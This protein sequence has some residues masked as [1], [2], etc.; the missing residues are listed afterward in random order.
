M[1]DKELAEM[2]EYKKIHTFW[3][4]LRSM[5]DKFSR[6][7]SIASCSRS[8]LN[9]SLDRRDMRKIREA[10][11]EIEAYVQKLRDNLDLL[12]DY[13]E[14]ACPSKEPKSVE[15]VE[16]GGE[17]TYKFVEGWISTVEKTEVIYIDIKL[18]DGKIDRVPVQIE[19]ST[20]ETKLE[21]VFDFIFRTNRLFG[22]A[23]GKYIDELREMMWKAFQ[24]KYE[25][26]YEN[27]LI[28][29]RLRV[30][31]MRGEDV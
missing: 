4:T 11:E 17:P 2:S 19:W 28:D 27:H 7:E 22:N 26:G 30:K 15:I 18:S 6:L 9:Y 23:Y 8:S 3:E 24:R 12:E 25:A 20:F 5:P 16:R 21:D 13:V 14:L 10:I 1:T 29:L 31:K